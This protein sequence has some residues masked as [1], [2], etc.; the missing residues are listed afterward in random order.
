[1]ETV[2]K[3]DSILY[4][5]IAA[6]TLI[7]F[8]ILTFVVFTREFGRLAEM[9]IRK[10]ASALI[11]LE[12][13]LSLLPSI[14]IFT[15]PLSFLIGALIGFSRLSSDSEIVAMQ[16]G[17]ISPYEMLRPALKLG[18][19]VT[20]VTLL[21]TLFLFPT[22]NWNLR[23]IRH[24]IG[25]QPV[26]S[27]IKP[28]VFNEDLP[29][30]ILYVEDVE[31][32]TAFWKGVFLA[33]ISPSGERRIIL[34]KEGRV[35]VAPDSRQLQLN[36][37]KGTIYTFN[38]ESSEESSLTR[39][40]VQDVAVRFPKM[41][42]VR[43]QPKRT[44]DKSLGELL[45]DL[46]RG[47]PETQRKSSVELQSRLALPFSALLFAVLGVTLGIRPHRGGR[48]YGFVLSMTIAF[49]YYTLFASG[50]QIASEGV[51]APL[52]GVWGTDIL[53]A[54]GALWSLRSSTSV[55]GTLNVLA[56]RTLWV[57]LM[58][59]LRNSVKGIA[60]I[61]LRLFAHLQQLWTFP[62]LGLRMARVIDLYILR[63]FLSFL[64]LTLGVC[65][66]L[67]YLFT[68]LELVDDI[69]TN[70]IPGTI[71]FNY[72]LYL[73][74]H[75][76]TLLVPISIL[77]A[78]LVT[79]GILDKTNQ[80]IALKSCGISLYRIFAPVLGLSLAV[81]ALLYVMQEHILP[82]SNQRQDN[83]R[84]L[85]KGRP[86]QTFYQPGRKWIFG[87]GNRLYT[88]N[89]Y[90][91]EQR[92]FAELSIFD[93][94]VGQSRLS[95]HTYAQKATWNERTQ[96]WNL[97]SGWTRGFEKEGGS[98]TTFKQRDIALPEG[99]DYFVKELWVKESSQMTYSE[100][101][102]YTQDLRKGGFE[103]DHL[104]TELHTKIALPV[105]NMIMAVLGV[106]FAF[107]MGRKGALYGIA[108]GVM[109]GIV[110]WGAFGVFGTLGVH[111]MLSPLLAAWGPN[112][113]FGSG[114]LLLLLTART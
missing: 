37:Q 47:S 99:P 75:I 84:N 46:K 96:S 65:A 83:L 67:F 39:F 22:A 77:I 64:L 92:I 87:E 8:L 113:L 98:F 14:L 114:G 29:G 78:T 16:A 35:L 70:N 26:R 86:I 73:L 30:T 66:S 56:H 109:I 1:M 24:E 34:S 80:I 62:K 15:F 69:F 106:P 48:S 55:P 13:I 36:F 43:S 93:L 60:R 9:L 103:V 17:G 101:R 50:K 74:P 53:L 112:I 5:E 90:D 11:I 97:S 7:A 33:D 107:S 3:I 41:E 72:F 61:V 85:I 18:T 104:R 51:L 10:D 110:Y 45:A 31:L 4:K 63:N 38:K 94:D 100:L 42:A 76:L 79:F 59:R 81:G 44:R 52:W 21:L 40:Q 12:V 108:V 28:R 57:R 102:A 111:G 32:A 19:S 27:K 91:S 68:F 49:G 6:P 71:V 89:Y 25:M 20:L 95:Q 88:Y 58:E 2:K 23:Q 105:V 54:C 82:Y